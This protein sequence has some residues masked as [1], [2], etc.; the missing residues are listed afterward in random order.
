VSRAQS[1]LSSA[2]PAADSY[3]A[4]TEP[5][6]YRP[7]MTARDAIKELRRDVQDG[8]LDAEAVEAVLAA[9][10]EKRAKR[11][12]GP[13]GLTPREIEVLRL[14]ARGA[15]NR[16]VAQALNITPETA[17]THIERIYVKTGATSRSTATL[18]AVQRG[19]LD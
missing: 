16:Q 11:P 2:I 7:A 13:A 6:A 5:R 14:I 4:M 8:R 3:H 17:G 18:F 1:I 19:L 10:G 9:T 15:S 12:A